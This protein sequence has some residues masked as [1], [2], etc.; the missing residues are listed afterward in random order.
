[1]NR[2]PP[3]TIQLING[4]KTRCPWYC[5]YCNAKYAYAIVNIHYECFCGRLVAY[6]EPDSGSCCSTSMR[7]KGIDYPKPPTLHPDDFEL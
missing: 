2:K 6:H 3:W 1:M 4:K 5:P 7:E